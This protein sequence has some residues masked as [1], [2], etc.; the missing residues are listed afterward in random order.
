MTLSSATF[1]YFIISLF[2]SS[3]RPVRAKQQP[4]PKSIG[5]DGRLPKATKGAG[6]R[7]GTQVP[8]SA[9]AVAEESLSRAA[10]AHP[11]SK[12]GAGPTRNVLPPREPIAPGLDRSTAQAAET[13]QHHQ[14]ARGKEPEEKTS[15]G[16]GTTSG[17]V[18]SSTAGE[19]GSESGTV[20]H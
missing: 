8:D 13:Q 7:S 11:V 20:T 10:N 9:G 2:F 4:P 14:Q 5:D 6:S 12:E 15:S 3:A 16:T 17:S 18:T 1:G 19:D